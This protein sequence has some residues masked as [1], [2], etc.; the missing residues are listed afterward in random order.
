MLELIIGEII[1]KYMFSHTFGELIL[2]KNHA[3]VEM[4]SHLN[5]LIEYDKSYFMLIKNS[6]L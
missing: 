5:K 1:I 4:Y 3:A 6:L 2:N